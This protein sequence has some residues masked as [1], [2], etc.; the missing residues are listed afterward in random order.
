MPPRPSGS[1][2]SYEPK[3]LPLVTVT[4]RLQGY[5]DVGDYSEP[6]S[7]V[8][9]GPMQSGCTRWVRVSIGACI[10]ASIVAAIATASCGSPAADRGGSVP[11]STPSVRALTAGDTAP[12]FSLQGSDGRQ[13]S[14]SSYR[15]KQAVVLAWFAKAFTEG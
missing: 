4:A 6:T 10:A 15:G 11:A 8:S 3:R 5:Q 1:M 13:Y 12:E 14:L 9:F 2:I 7:V